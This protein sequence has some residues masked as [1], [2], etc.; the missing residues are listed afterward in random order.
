MQTTLN[1]DETIVERLYAEA[2]RRGTTASALAEAGILN[3]LKE[4]P[5]AATPDKLEDPW[6]ELPKWT[7]GGELV[8]ITNK[9]ELYRVMDEYDGFRYV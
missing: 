1:I 4:V 5:T 3:I 9:E 7:S 6:P 2:K 8:D